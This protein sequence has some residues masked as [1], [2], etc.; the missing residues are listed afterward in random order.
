VERTLRWLR[1]PWPL[2]GG[3]NRRALALYA[4]LF[5]ASVIVD[6]VLR[7]L[8]VEEFH[9]AARLLGEREGALGG[10]VGWIQAEPSRFAG[11]NLL[12]CGLACA[13]LFR[14]WM[15][16]SLVAL[17]ACH[18][19]LLRVF[20]GLANQSEVIAPY[21]LVFLLLVDLRGRRPSPRRASAAEARLGVLCNLLALRGLQAQLALLYLFN[22]LTKLVHRGWFEGSAAADVTAMDWVMTTDLP[23][24]A[25]LPVLAGA[26]T[27]AA[28]LYEVLFPLWMLSART[29]GPVVLFGV[30][31]HALIAAAMNQLS[32]LSLMTAAALVLF[33]YPDATVRRLTGRARG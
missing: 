29:R 12:Y 1:R 14:R 22:G 6:G 18:F 13:A 4:R 20:A 7:Q 3:L 2:A 24:L 27:Y 21:F 5:L 17:F 26:L 9:A 23:W 15:R 16:P 31:M 30:A 25:G 32:G 10:L 33:H 19:V 8:H 11:F 28:L